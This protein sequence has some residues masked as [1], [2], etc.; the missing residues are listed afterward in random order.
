MLGPGRVCSDERQ[1]DFGLHRGREFTLGL[2]S[3]LF[4][5]LQRHRILTKVHSVLRLE[6]V[7]QPIDDGLV[8]VVTSQMRVSVGRLDFEHAVSE[9]ED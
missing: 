4:E 3:C 6:F 7:G 2:L 1:I 5:S 9:F 8:E